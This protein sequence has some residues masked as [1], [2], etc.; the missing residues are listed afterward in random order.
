[1]PLIG[2]AMG[3]AGL[4]ALRS[5]MWTFR[6]VGWVLCRWAGGGMPGDGIAMAWLWVKVFL[7]GAL[8][9]RAVMWVRRAVGMARP[10]RGRRTEPGGGWMAREGT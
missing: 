8:R 3:R 4:K 9:I 10:C 6:G 1:M 7:E 2:V 5:E